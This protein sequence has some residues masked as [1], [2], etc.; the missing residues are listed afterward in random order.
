MTEE[1][2]ISR[3]KAKIAKLLKLYKLQYRRLQDILRTRHELYVQRMEKIKDS[4]VPKLD[5]HKDGSGNQDIKVGSDGIEKE[6]QD[7]GAELDQTLSMRASFDEAEKPDKGVSTAIM[8][9]NSAELRDS[10]TATP[11]SMPEKSMAER[12]AVDPGNSDSKP[13]DGKPVAA[14]AESMKEP[15]QV[16]GHDGRD[17]S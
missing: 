4:E 16:C 12:M 1:E 6:G 15:G 11:S 17:M 7:K 9:R 3:R 5:K 2:T 8:D 10:G 13:D 14:S